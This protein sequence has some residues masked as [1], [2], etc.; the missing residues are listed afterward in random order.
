MTW[1]PL[2]ELGALFS[3]GMRHEQERRR[4]ADM[5]REEEGTSADPPNMIDLDSGVV[6]LG[7]VAD[8]EPEEGADPRHP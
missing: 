5:M 8:G 1:G 7:P 3:P 4:S 2:G 6:V